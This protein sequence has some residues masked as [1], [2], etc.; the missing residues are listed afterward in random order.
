MSARVRGSAYWSGDLG[1]RDDDGYVYFAGRSDDWLRVDGE[2]VAV[3]PIE[4]ILL[5]HPDVSGAVVYAVPDPQVGDL[6]MAAL[7]LQP[8]AEFDSDGFAAFLTAQ[9]DLGTKMA[10]RFVRISLIPVTATM[11]PIRRDLRREAW[12]CSDPVWWRPNS[13]DGQY[14]RLTAD[15]VE[16]RWDHGP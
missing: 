10:P 15:D 16:D 12:T 6:V 1:Y 3:A 5:R 8:G 4:Q 9:P 11:K 13:R 7:E 14:R 2:N